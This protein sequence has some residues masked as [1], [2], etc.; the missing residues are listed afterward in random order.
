MIDLQKITEVVI[1]ISVSDFYNEK[2]KNI[3]LEICLLHT[4]IHIT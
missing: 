1:S 2:L 4:Y 3:F